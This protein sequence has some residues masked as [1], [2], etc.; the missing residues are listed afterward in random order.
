M[1]L[2]C[3]PTPTILSGSNIAAEGGA[4][5]GIFFY[6]ADLP[7]GRASTPPSCAGLWQDFRGSKRDALARPLPSAPPRPRAPAPRR[8]TETGSRGASPRCCVR[9]R[10]PG[11]RRAAP[12]PPRPPR[13][14]HPRPPPLLALPPLALPL[15][16]KRKGEINLV[17]L[18]PLALPLGKGGMDLAPGAGSL[19]LTLPSR[20]PPRRVTGSQR[21]PSQRPAT[22]H[23]PH[24]RPTRRCTPHRCLA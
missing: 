2:T 3:S 20:G 8:A 9:R 16:V 11:C 7:K 23:R 18:P 12:P 13:R 14:H 5:G 4:Y 15:G 19:S 22:P 17:A 6:G 24:W 1:R 10:R 21:R